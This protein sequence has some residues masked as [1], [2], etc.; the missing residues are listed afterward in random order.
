MIFNKGIYKDEELDGK[1]QDVHERKEDLSVYMQGGLSFYQPLSGIM[2][3]DRVVVYG[4]M[5]GNGWA[6]SNPS[7]LPDRM[8]PRRYGEKNFLKN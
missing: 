2:A 4:P 1:K 6:G 8:K 5:Q 7:W 3:R